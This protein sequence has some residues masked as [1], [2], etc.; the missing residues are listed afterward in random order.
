[1]ADLGKT[2]AQWDRFLERELGMTILAPLRYLRE[3]RDRFD[4]SRTQVRVINDVDTNQAGVTLANVDPGNDTE[5]DGRL[6]VRIT[7]GPTYTV[8]IYKA[9]G[10]GG[11]DAIAAGSGTASS[12]VTLTEQNSSGVSGTW[13]LPGSVTVTADD[14]LQ[15]E[16]VLDF[17]ALLPFVYTQTDGI[18]DDKDSRR[19][20]QAAYDQIAALQNQAI[21]VLE[22]AAAAMLLGDAQNETGRGNDFASSGE[23]SLQTETVNTDESGNVSRSRGG[24]FEVLRQA[25]A[26]ETTGSTQAVVE[27]SVSAAAGVATSTNQGQG[28]IASHTPLEKCQEGRLFLECVDDTIGSEL[29]SGYFYINAT[30]RRT[31]VS[32]LQV[33]K[34]WSGPN[35]LGPIA[36]QRT[37][38]KT[39]DVGSDTDLGPI[40]GFAVTGETSANTDDGV[41]Y[42][43]IVASGGNWDLSFYSASTRSTSTL[44]AKAENYATGA[45]FV[46]TA[47]NGSGMTV[48]GTIGSGPTTTTAGTLNLNVFKVENTNN[49][50]D[51]F[52]VSVTV[53]ASPGLVQTILAQHFSENGSQ[54]NSTTA[55]A[56]TFQDNYVRAN[57]FASFAVEDN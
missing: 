18:E 8:T 40:A 54:L 19:V 9:T 45:A 5:A 7:G 43:E 24:L 34:S 55:G 10:G 50:R 1:M 42:W 35:G 33:G 21:G 38:S 25:M 29:F 4:R 13:T 12:T 36:L 47:A 51:S 39:G 44:V 32:G 41:L 57:T 15:L 26:D 48:T 11:G 14:S 37:L 16:V 20:M 6:Y 22:I 3:S 28:T 53:A 2:N 46:A 27:R 49:V 17:S 31:P 30:D 23:T 56:E 52:S